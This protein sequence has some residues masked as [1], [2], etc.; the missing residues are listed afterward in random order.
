MY[1]LDVTGAPSPEQDPQGYIEAV[2]G[3][4]L[5]LW[6]KILDA[7]HEAASVAAATQAGTLAHDTA[8]TALANLQRLAKVHTATVR[9]VEE[10][11]GYLNLGR[12]GLGSVPVVVLTAFAAL[13]AIIAW[14][15]RE[16]EAQRDLLDM[17]E[18]G[19]LTPEQA[20]A[21]QDTG[22]APP[23]A[24]L[25]GLGMGAG[26]LALLALIILGPLA[27]IYFHFKR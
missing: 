9:K 27:A 15:F 10:Y 17:I 8:R 14:S 23:P 25:G 11:Q 7:M 21:I 2:W 12:A 19:T 22:P 16:Y 3:S 24:I 18:A 5:A 4:Y 26:G 1:A 6:P 13:A 20:A